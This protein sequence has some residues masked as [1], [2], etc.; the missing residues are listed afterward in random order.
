MEGYCVTEAAA[1][2]DMM[3]GCSLTYGFSGNMEQIVTSWKPP[4]WNSG[5]VLGFRSTLL[6]WNK[7][8]LLTKEVNV[9]GTVYEK[10][11]SD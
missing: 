2:F 11:F 5:F 1:E 3:E 4:R 8:K 9:C 10:A 7:K 6:N